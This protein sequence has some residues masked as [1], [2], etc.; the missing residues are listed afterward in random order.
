MNK[1]LGSAEWHFFAKSHRKG[2]ADGM[3]GT[4]KRLAAKTSLQ[5]VYNNHIQT[6]CELFNYCNSNIHITCFY[7]QE[8]QILNKKEGT[9]RMIFYGSGNT[10]NSSLSLFQ[11]TELQGNHYSCYF[12]VQIFHNTPNNKET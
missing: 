6:P 2:P 7:V 9:C 12:S 3:G 4:L 5:R 1:M 10:R 8:E 11:A